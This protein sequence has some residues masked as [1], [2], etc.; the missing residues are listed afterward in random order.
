MD[1]NKQ[2]PCCL[3]C[4]HLIFGALLFL[5]IRPTSPAP[6]QVLRDF[7]APEGVAADALDAAGDGE[8]LVV[9]DLRSDPSLVEAGVA[10]E[11]VNRWVVGGGWE[12]GPGH[13]AGLAG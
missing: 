1:R 7:R 6:S 9:V 8:V 10:R 13:G 11:V 12:V 2:S 4:P 5:H 3:F